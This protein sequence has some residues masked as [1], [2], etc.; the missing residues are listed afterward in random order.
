MDVRTVRH[1][2]HGLRL[3]FEIPASEHVGASFACEQL[4]CGV[5]TWDGVLQVSSSILTLGNNMRSILQ[6]PA[7]SSAG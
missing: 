1:A 7:Y 3:F 2:R 5:L 6:A 4:A